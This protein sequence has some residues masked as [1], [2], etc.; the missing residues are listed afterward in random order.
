LLRHFLATLLLLLFISAPAAACPKKRAGVKT[1]SD[2]GAASIP[3]DAETTTFQWLAQQPRPSEEAI[4]KDERVPPIE[5][6]IFHLRAVLTTIDQEPDGDLKLH[7][8][9]EEDPKVK[10]VAE[11]PQAGCVPSQFQARIKRLRD[12]LKAL[13]R[14]L[15]KT[16]ELQGVGYWG[17]VREDETAP[18]GVQLHP[19]LQMRVIQQGA[20]PRANAP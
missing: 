17:Y 2:P 11:V 12:Q 9:S 14:S 20:A 5:Y 18:N 10:M 4:G 13:A 19:V 6:K 16:V 3:A 1:L 7:L 8:R 15:P